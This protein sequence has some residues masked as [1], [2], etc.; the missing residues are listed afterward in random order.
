MLQVLT[1][2]DALDRYSFNRMVVTNSL[3][4]SSN[5]FNCIIIG[6]KFLTYFIIPVYTFLIPATS[7]FLLPLLPCVHVLLLYFTTSCTSFFFHII[8]YMHSWTLFY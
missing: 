1:A 5:L 3:P 4:T 6:L 7:V 2:P 8:S